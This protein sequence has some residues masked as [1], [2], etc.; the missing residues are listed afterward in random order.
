MDFSKV[1]DALNKVEPGLSKYLYIMDK[2]HRTDV[3]S[4][5]EFQKRFNGFY[6]MRQRKPEFYEEYYLF[7]EKNKNNDV[8]FEIVLEYLYK[9]FQRVEGKR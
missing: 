6:R 8:S 1:N 4:D 2:L 5:L 7:M 9:L 3:S